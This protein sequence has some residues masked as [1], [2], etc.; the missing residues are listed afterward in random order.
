MLLVYILLGVAITC[1]LVI[2]VL[3][4]VMLARQ[5]ALLRRDRATA[6]LAEQRARAGHHITR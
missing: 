1:G 4:N 3:L 2:V 5:V 6:D